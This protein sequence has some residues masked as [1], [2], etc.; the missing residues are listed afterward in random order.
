ML[1]G[2]GGLQRIRTWPIAKGFGNKNERF[3]NLCVIPTVA[4]LM[5]EQHKITSVVDAGI[6]PGIVE[7]H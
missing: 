2:N 4:V 3:G 5:L 1:G 6:A 7:Q